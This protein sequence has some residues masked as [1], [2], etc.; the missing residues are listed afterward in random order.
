MK[1]QWTDWLRELAQAGKGGDGLVLPPI[2][3]DKSYL[4]VLNIEANVSADAFAADLRTAPDSDLA[5]LV[6]FT[7]SVGAFSG[8]VTPVTLS[9]TALQTALP[10]VADADFNGLAEA[11]FYLFH[12]PSGGTQ[13]RA[14]GTVIT[15]AE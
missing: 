15:I 6:A 14:A 12:T 11:V 2:T 8:G 5:P 4:H 10:G 1:S 7:V 13:Y 9:L 3:R